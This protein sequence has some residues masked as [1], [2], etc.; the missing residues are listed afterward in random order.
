MGNGRV[1]SD[2]PVQHVLDA[3][4]TTRLRLP[5]PEPLKSTFFIQWLVLDAAA[6]ALAPGFIRTAADEAQ[7]D[8]HILMRF[9]LERDRARRDVFVGFV[10]LE[11]AVGGLLRR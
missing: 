9:D 11:A 5:I 1:F 3:A 10:R 6:N 7:Y 8:L 4:G 2:V